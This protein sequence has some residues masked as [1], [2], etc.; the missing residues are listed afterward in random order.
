MQRLKQN[1]IIGFIFVSVLGTLWHFLYEWTGN[2]T[3]IGFIAP[4]NESTFE[5]MKLVFFPSLI[6]MPCE[7]HFLKKNY[8]YITNAMSCGILAG[9]FFLPVFFYS[10][11]GIIGRNYMAVDIA[12]FFLCVFVT[13]FTTYRLCVKQKKMSDISFYLILLTALFFVALTYRHPEIGIFIE[14]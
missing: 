11:S 8:P 3:L 1:L 7:I 4:I 2:N 5:H 13:F 10:Y 6:Y 12:S 9:T 14:P